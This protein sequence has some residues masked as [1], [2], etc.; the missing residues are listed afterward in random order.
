MDRRERESMKKL[1]DFLFSAK[2]LKRAGVSFLV[3][4]YLSFRLFDPFDYLL[5]PWKFWSCFSVIVIVGLVG[6][7]VWDS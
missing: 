7:Y 1:L 2:F 5:S 3:A 4:F 6:I